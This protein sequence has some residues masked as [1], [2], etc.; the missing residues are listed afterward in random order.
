M[1]VLA[2]VP[3]LNPRRSWFCGNR[4]GVRRSAPVQ[5][6]SIQPA[7]SNTPY[8]SA[9]S[10]VSKPR[11]GARNVSQLLSECIE[12]RV[13]IAILGS[14]QKHWTCR[15]RYTHMVSGFPIIAL[16]QSPLYAPIVNPATL[17]RLSDLLSLCNPCKRCKSLFLFFFLQ[18]YKGI[19]IGLTALTLI[20]I[21]LV[22]CQYAKP[23][24]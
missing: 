13:N 20:L 6:R 4:S 14:W 9:T 12:Q 19:E 22:E 5:P 8:T 17:K 24:R 10:A 16:H 15:C 18:S 21:R 1:V 23:D 3:R 2:Y 7:P 11:V